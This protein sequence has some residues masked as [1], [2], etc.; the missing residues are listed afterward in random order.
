MTKGG[1][2]ADLAKILG[3]SVQAVGKFCAA[4]KV[5]FSFKDGKRW[6]HDLDGARQEYLA[7]RDGGRGQ[8]RAKADEAGCG[9]GAG[10]PVEEEA[11]EKVESYAKS[12]AKLQHYKALLE[13]LK[14]QI[15]IGTL[16]RKDDLDKAVFKFHRTLRDRILNVPDRL[17]AVLAGETDQANVHAV[18]ARELRQALSELADEAER[19][20]ANAPAVEEG[21]G[22]E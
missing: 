12:A 20:E 21:G 3:I 15:E 1:S 19:A 9:V 22:D 5:S 4:G 14:Y 13:E 7:A 2:A 17:A 8:R 18:L 10:A 6:F 11:D 16:V